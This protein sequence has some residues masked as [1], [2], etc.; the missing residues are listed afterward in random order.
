MRLDKFLSDMNQGTRKELK[1]KIKKGSVTVNGHTCSDPGQQVAETD[2]IIFDGKR[3]T[4]YR[5]EY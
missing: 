2:Q 3:I 5:Y 1:E 4:Y